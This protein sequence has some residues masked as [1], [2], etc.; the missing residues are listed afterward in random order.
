MVG[1]LAR[2]VYGLH[3]FYGSSVWSRLGKRRCTV[4]QW[5]IAARRCLFRLGP[6]YGHWAR[7]VSR[8]R[9]LRMVCV[10]IRALWRPG[11]PQQFLWMISTDP[12]DVWGEYVNYLTVWFLELAHYM[13]GSRWS[14]FLVDDVSTTE[15]LYGTLKR[16]APSAKLVCSTPA[17]LSLP[18]SLHVITDVQM[19]GLIK[20]HKR[21][22]PILRQ[23]SR[24]T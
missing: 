5:S 23:F 18:T 13:H 1:T 24:V 21:T 9:W 14:Q 19:H 20:P 17:V 15:L 7:S 12:I 16:L 22:S 11:F 4:T 6:R 3:L 10:Y 2:A 8:L